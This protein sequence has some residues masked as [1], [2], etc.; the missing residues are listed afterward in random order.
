SIAE[1]WPRLAG[2]FVPTGQMALTL[3]VAHVFLGLGV[4]EELGRLENQSLPFSVGSALAF[5]L[6]AMVFSF[7]WLRRFRRGPLEALMR[8][9]CS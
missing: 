8:K 1:C 4:L 3:Y 6:G 5:Y 9:L 2:V 7:L